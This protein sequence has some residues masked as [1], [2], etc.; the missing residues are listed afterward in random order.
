MPQSTG[1]VSYIGE[2]QEMKENFTKRDFAIEV[3]HHDQ[4]SGVEYKFELAFQLTNNNTG[5]LDAFAFGQPVTVSFGIRSNR[6]E[7]D[8]EIKY[9]TNLNAFK[10]EAAGPTPSLHPGSAPNGTPF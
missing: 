6:T 2:V 1:T 4:Y 7:K 10:L 8:G 5:L 9:F 3:T